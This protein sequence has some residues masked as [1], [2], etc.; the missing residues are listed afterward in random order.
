LRRAIVLVIA[1]GLLLLLPWLAGVSNLNRVLFAGFLL[2]AFMITAWSCV[3]DSRDR[4]LLISASER[5][6][7]ASARAK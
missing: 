3:L 1:F 7:G 5:F 6:R 2:T 4:S